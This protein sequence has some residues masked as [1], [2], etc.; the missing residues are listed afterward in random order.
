MNFWEK[1]P[2]KEKPDDSWGGN[3]CHHSFTGTF[4]PPT[5][6]GCR[7]DDV[8]N[9]EDEANS[10]PESDMDDDNLATVASSGDEES[11]SKNNIKEEPGSVERSSDNTNTL[12]P[13]TSKDLS[14]FLENLISAHNEDSS[15]GKS[16]AVLPQPPTT[17][18][19]TSKRKRSGKNVPKHRWTPPPKI[20]KVRTIRVLAF[21]WALIAQHLH[22]CACQRLHGD[23]CSC[24]GRS[25]HTEVSKETQLYFAI[26][27]CLSK[28][29]LFAFVV[30]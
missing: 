15:D 10:H 7:S 5:Q 25:A 20:P 4:S 11:D 6:A 17:Q 9:G 24:S 30:F 21:S 23:V 8:C 14:S 12:D 13:E 26:E 27:L 22:N 1:W 2:V 29:T 28:A 19:T 18:P 16:D 3:I